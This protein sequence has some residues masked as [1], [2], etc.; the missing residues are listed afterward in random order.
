[1]FVCAYVMQLYLGPNIKMPRA[2]H[3][4]IH[5]SL[6]NFKIGGV[7]ERMPEPLLQAF[8]TLKKAAAM[9]NKEFGLEPAMSDTISAACDEVWYFEEGGVSAACDDVWYFEEVVWYFEEGDMVL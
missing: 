4:F 6:Q 8:G 1:M 7:R 5:S 3:H 9:V 2:Y